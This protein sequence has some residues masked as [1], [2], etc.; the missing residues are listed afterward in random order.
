[1]NEIKLLRALIAK[2]AD[3][4]KKAE[5]EEQLIKAIEKDAQEKADAK[6]EAKNKAAMD[7]LSAEAAKLRSQFGGMASEVASDGKSV[8]L[9][10]TAGAPGMYKGYRFKAEMANLGLK[11]KGADHAMFRANMQ[12]NPQR[13]E[14][15]VKTFLDMYE[16]AKKNPGQEQAIIK[17]GMNEGT[18]T[19]GGWLTPDEFSD[20]W[21]S[22]TRDDSVA[23]QFCRIERMLSDVKYVNKEDA[24]VNS[25]GGVIITNEATAATEVN[26]T[27]ART[28]LTAKRL[29]GYTRITVEDMEDAQV[30]GGL[31]NQLMDQFSEANG[32]TIDSAVF[33]GAGDPCSGVFKSAGYSQTFDT[34]SSNFSELL[35][36][37]IRGLI[38]KVLHA[39]NPR[40]F[41]HRTILWNYIYGLKDTTGRPL[42]IPSLAAGGPQTVHGWPISEVPKGPSTSAASTG[43]ILFGDLKG[44][45]IGERA[46]ST[47]FFVDPFTRGLSHEVI[48]A[49][50]NRYAFAQ[51][52]ANMYGRIVTAA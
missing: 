40:F 5:Y 26:P 2:E 18:T 43:F 46:R 8:G 13:A 9:G 35:E 45:I 6:A 51:H 10:I 4:V 14:A 28:T 38:A 37:D 21:S 3:P 12:A 24:T 20:E 34:G 32:Q 36:S 48:F 16:M 17:A 44:F 30:R 11:G 22:Y 7:A 15:F 47:S 41:A 39:P 33:I 19:A 42:F 1:M 31:V 52:M 23:L 50:F 29:D 27:V 49:L 25:L